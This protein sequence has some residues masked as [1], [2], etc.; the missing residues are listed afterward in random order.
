MN[1]FEDLIVELKQENLLESTVIDHE[2][3]EG[4]DAYH[5]DVTEVPNA[6]F[7]SDETFEVE[8]NTAVQEPLSSQTA[9][10][11]ETVEVAG[12]AGQA[13]EIQTLPAPKA[14][15]PRKPKNGKEFY[16][17]RAV[18]EVSHLQMVE[19]VLTGIEREYLKVVPHTYDDFGV[20]KT[21]HAFLHITD[22]ENSALHAEAEFKMMQ[23]TEAWCSALGDRDRKIEVSSLRQYC[24]NSRPPL[25]SQALL[26]L[27]RFYRNL[28]YS[29]SVRAKFDFVIT[30]LFS[31]SSEHERRACLFTRDESLTHIN[32]LYKEWS[33]IALY[34]AEDD[35]SKVLLTALSF[36]DLAI[37]A[38]NAGTFDQLIESEFFG[39]LRLF[40]ES[41]SELF[42]APNV[43]AAA[44]EANVRIGNAYVSLIDREHQKMDAESIQTKY[45][46]LHDSEISN[47]TARTLEL[48]EL[49]RIRPSPLES[50]EIA[51]DEAEI[52]EIKVPP[53]AS[54]VKKKK[55]PK[56]ATVSLPFFDNIRDKALSVNKWLLFSAFLLI[57]LSVGVY[58][59]GNYYVRE[60]ATTA[61]VK[62]VEIE[63]AV[64]KEH[65]NT[66][67][68]SG[69]NFYAMLAPS[70]DNLPKEKRQEFLQKLFQFASEKG[71]K[72]VS[73]INNAGKPAGYASATRLDV[74]MP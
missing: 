45:G 68:I 58:V 37:E 73:L 8:D 43:T 71:C 26:S 33:S 5:L 12:L 38:E 72:Q 10:E 27:A 35:E 70:W 32:T 66:V 41:I 14:S 42:Y 52:E 64:L 59:W 18:D 31:R 7:E 49:L 23:E 21:L 57:T 51:E 24:E 69:E 53:P 20:K 48:V 9:F 15:Q 13:D 62:T 54:A 40:K 34:S 44:I 3:P 1:V 28:P 22:N 4:F 17:K 25:S 19:H 65:I 55:L 11:I 39:R 2:S 36:D 63:S 67:R 61:G 29:E 30:R 74:T 6:R 56:S 50:M 47:A 60:D 16:K 46:D